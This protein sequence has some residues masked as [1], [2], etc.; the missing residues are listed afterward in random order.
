MSSNLKRT[1]WETHPLLPRVNKLKMLK[2]LPL[3]F[4]RLVLVSSQLDLPPP[5]PFNT[6]HSSLEDDLLTLRSDDASL[7]ASLYVGTKPELVNHLFLP[8]NK[9]ISEHQFHTMIGEQPD[10]NGALHSCWCKNCRDIVSAPNER[11]SDAIAED[12][13]ERDFRVPIKVK[14]KINSLSPEVNE[15]LPTEYRFQPV[16]MNIVQLIRNSTEL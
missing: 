6:K 7:L 4:E 8:S 13:I 12:F 10:A 3:A 9:T 14:H 2:Y 5:A 11:I 15:R 1:I 16:P